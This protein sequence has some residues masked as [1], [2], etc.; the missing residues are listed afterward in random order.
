MRLFR[1]AVPGQSCFP[2]AKIG[3]P[4]GCPVDKTSTFARG[5]GGGA[6]MVFLP[7][8]QDLLSGPRPRVYL[9][10]RKSV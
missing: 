10:E 9:G 7:R 6:R 5:G 4:V 3:G 1:L 8:G 2:T